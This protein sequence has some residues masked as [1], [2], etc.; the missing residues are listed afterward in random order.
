MRFDELGYPA[1]QGSTDFADSSH[2]AGVL[3]VTKHPLQVDCLNYVYLWRATEGKK[4]INYIRH[5]LETRYDFS[6]DQAILLM[7]GLI[8][9]GH[10]EYVNLDFITGKDI[11]PPSVRGLVQ[12]AQGKK[13]TLIQR[14]WLKGEI[15]WH[16]YLQPLDEPNQIIALCLSYG[17]E[18]LKLWTSKNKLWKWSVRRYWSELDGAWRNEKE[19]C[20]HI[21]EF[22]ENKTRP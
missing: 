20:D 13:P 3:A 8:A 12:I 18:Y 16:S 14:L 22:I 15:Y 1:P 10:N 21:I 19:L 7:S 17:D 6:R 11:L 2:L 5:P 9:Q 4:W